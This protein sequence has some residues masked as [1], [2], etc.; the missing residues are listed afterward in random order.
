[1]FYYLKKIAT[2]IALLCVIVGSLSASIVDNPPKPEF[3]PDCPVAPNTSVY[4]AKLEEIKKW[5]KDQDSTGNFFN[6]VFPSGLPSNKGDYNSQALNPKVKYTQ[7]YDTRNTLTSASTAKISE[8]EEKAEQYRVQAKGAQQEAERA[9]AEVKAVEQRLTTETVELQEQLVAQGAGGDL[10]ARNPRLADVYTAAIANKV[11]LGNLMEFSDDAQWVLEIPY[12]R[13]GKQKNIIVPF[14][15]KHQLDDAVAE[16]TIKFNANVHTHAEILAEFTTRS[17]DLANLLSDTT[18]VIDFMNAKPKLGFYAITLPFKREDGSDDWLLFPYENTLELKEAFAKAQLFM[19][20]GAGKGGRSV[21]YKQVLTPRP[22]RPTDEPPAVTA[23]MDAYYLLLDGASKNQQ[24]KDT[25]NNFKTVYNEAYIAIE[26]L[27]NAQLEFNTLDA[28]LLNVEKLR[29]L[30]GVYQGRGKTIENL[31]TNIRSTI[32]KVTWNTD[33]PGHI[34]DFFENFLLAWVQAQELSSHDLF[35]KCIEDFC[36]CIKSMKQTA[37]V[38]PHSFKAFEDALVADEKKVKELIAEEEQKIYEEAVLNF[39][40]TKREVDEKINRLGVEWDI[41]QISEDDIRRHNKEVATGSTGFLEGHTSS[42]IDD[43]GQYKKIPSL[44]YFLVNDP[45]FLLIALQNS[46]VLDLLTTRPN[47]T[48]LKPEE[49]NIFALFENEL[50]HLTLRE[51]QAF[52]VYL[53]NIVAEFSALDRSYYDIT[54]NRNRITVSQIEALLSIVKK[55]FLLPTNP[56]Y[57]YTEDPKRIKAFV[58]L[59]ISF[60]SGALARESVRKALNETLPFLTEKLRGK[61][62][63][64]VGDIIELAEISGRDIVADKATLANCMEYVAEGFDV[65]TIIARKRPHEILAE[66][67]VLREAKK[68]VETDR[69]ESLSLTS[70]EDLAKMKAQN[71]VRATR[72]PTKPSPRKAPSIAAVSAS[73]AAGGGGIVKKAVSPIKPSVETPDQLKTRLLGEINAIKANLATRDL[74]V[75]PFL[76]Q[77]EDIL[78]IETAIEAMDPHPKPML[79]AMQEG[80]IKKIKKALGL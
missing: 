2:N 1:M 69:F 23:L 50:E 78:A 24:I 65:A 38:N 79:L 44:L 28:I 70:A 11:E 21:Q 64:V 53:K 16:A 13:N 36:Q 7:W 35:L 62:V 56:N 29:E 22:A 72:T 45:V 6:A 59:L 5:F 66:I 15:S 9:K 27:C 47:S 51:R 63:E 31:K 4:Q 32:N 71:A 58:K 52:F 19:N 8:V 12:Q 76:S 75:E 48:M 40:A 55:S 57:R 49:K 41:A 18:V 80:K 74:G 46:T 37:I 61:T 60:G 25:V 10:I 34:G 54:T 42:R 14:D 67:E 20:I 39:D 73:A 77:N 33:I 30:A 3:F 68:V 26:L 17:P 43:K